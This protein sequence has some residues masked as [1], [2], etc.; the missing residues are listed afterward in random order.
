MG[1]IN[2]TRRSNRENPT[3][4][5]FTK[6][7]DAAVTRIDGQQIAIVRVELS[8]VEDAIRAGQT[9][10]AYQRTFPRATVAVLF[11]FSQES[12]AEAQYFGPPAV[13]AELVKIDPR[14]FQWRRYRRRH[15]T[16]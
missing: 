11:G 8:I 5:L 1:V 3:S 13:L 9:L 7:F 2:V 14:R 10:A 15:R 4:S 6:P 12:D 16:K